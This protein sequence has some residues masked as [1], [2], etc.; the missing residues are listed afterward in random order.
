[1]AG[2]D[3]IKSSEYNAKFNLSTFNHKM[4][5]DQLVERKCA[6]INTSSS[7]QAFLSPFSRSFTPPAL[8]NNPFAVGKELT[9]IPL[10]LD[11]V[12][13]VSR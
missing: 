11:L 6:S 4:W 3:P 7:T 9:I 5:D 2:I 8:I 13:F 1:M 12:L 10:L